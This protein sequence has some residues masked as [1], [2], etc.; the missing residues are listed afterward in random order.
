MGKQNRESA[1]HKVR[2]TIQENMTKNILLW[3]YQL[4]SRQ[5]WGS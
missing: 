3:R 5:I 1:E 2:K 4:L